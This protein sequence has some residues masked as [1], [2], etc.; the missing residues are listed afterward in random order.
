M[1]VRINKF[2]QF[3]LGLFSVRW[4]A[5]PIP[6]LTGYIPPDQDPR[7]V[8][9]AL[10]A[11]QITLTEKDFPALNA[12]NPDQEQASSSR[13]SDPPTDTRKLTVTPAASTDNT[14]KVINTQKETEL[15]ENTKQKTLDL[16]KEEEKYLLDENEGDENPIEVDM[17]IVT[18]NENRV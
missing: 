18:E 4:Q 3:L 8:R 6:G 12:G 9:K 17:E 7:D 15:D 2:C 11:N 14:E 10:F 13:M 1:A 5:P 16:S